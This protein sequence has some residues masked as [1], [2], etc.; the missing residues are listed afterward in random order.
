MFLAGFCS[1]TEVVLVGTDDG[2][3][4]GPVEHVLWTTGCSCLMD[5]IVRFEFLVKKLQL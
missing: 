3:G 2:V 4:A 5:A 1:S